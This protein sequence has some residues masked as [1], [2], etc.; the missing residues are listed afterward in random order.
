MMGGSPDMQGW[1]AAQLRAYRSLACNYLS[2]YK[3][4]AGG[5][6]VSAASGT[7]DSLFGQ[8]HSNIFAC[9]TG[10]LL[11]FALVCTAVWKCS[12]SHASQASCTCSIETLLTCLSF[13][14]GSCSSATILVEGAPCPY[15]GSF[16]EN[17]SVAGSACSSVSREQPEKLI[18]NEHAKSTQLSGRA[19]HLR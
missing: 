13:Q 14:S 11:G 3:E 2:Y 1:A 5:T 16:P 6:T 12:V 10:S 17:V 8:L 19:V 9:V 7:P 18:H 4:K 15:E